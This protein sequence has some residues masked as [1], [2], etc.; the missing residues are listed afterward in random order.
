MILL[1]ITR[2]GKVI[3]QIEFVSEADPETGHAV[4][5]F[6]NRMSRE[7]AFE[8]LHQ[9][10]SGSAFTGSLDESTHLWV[11]RDNGGWLITYE[12]A[13]DVAINRAELTPT[14]EVAGILDLLLSPGDEAG[15]AG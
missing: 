5:S 10:K 15:K 1:N 3:A 14:L 11:N 8:V 7:Q 13:D 9:R 12:W 4:V 6:R 2:G